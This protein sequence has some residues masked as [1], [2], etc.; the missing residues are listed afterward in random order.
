MTSSARHSSL[1]AEALI[2]AKLETGKRS[3]K[4]EPNGELHWVEGARSAVVPLKKKKKKKRWK[5][6]EED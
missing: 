3:Q 2:D 4:T 1:H 5:E 6:K